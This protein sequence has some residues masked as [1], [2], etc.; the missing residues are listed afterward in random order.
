MLIPVLVIIAAGIGLIGG[1]LLYLADLT[2]RKSSWVKLVFVLLAA[3]GLVLMLQDSHTLQRE[4]ARRGWPTA[5]GRVISSTV[6]QTRGLQPKIDF[7][8]EVDGVRYRSET[9][10]QTPAFGGKNTRLQAAET[11]VAHYPPGTA[12]TVHYN[13][14]NPAE[15]YLKPGPTWDVLM[16]L[17]L[18]VFLAAGG[19]AGLSAGMYVSIQHANRTRG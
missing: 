5:R 18:G 10:L 12:V 11:V 2:P 3:A 17:S 15:S 9:N 4:M 16:K 8:Y 13:P 7:E 14:T 19:I 6:S 1:F